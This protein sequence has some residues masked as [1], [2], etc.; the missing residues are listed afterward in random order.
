MFSNIYEIWQSIENT[1]DLISK[2]AKF[3]SISKYCNFVKSVMVDELNI[4]PHVST[5]AKNLPN[6]RTFLEK[7][8]LHHWNFWKKD[9]WRRGVK[10]MSAVATHQASTGKGV[11]KG[12]NQPPLLPL[13][14]WWVIITPHHLAHYLKLPFLKDSN[15][16]VGF[17]PYLFWS[18]S[19]LLP[20]CKHSWYSLNVSHIS[21]EF[22]SL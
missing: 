6:E 10:H 4:G 21:K 1:F 8:W 13:L 9:M 17:F 22:Q 20:L 15:G 18:S 11:C 19:I 3:E 14:A 16:V 2:N 12:C 5:V 7:N